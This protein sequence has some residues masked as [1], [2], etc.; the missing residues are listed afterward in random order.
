MAAV[1]A[2]LLK[3]VEIAA[4]FHKLA[5][6]GTAAFLLLDA[7][8]DAPLSARA[9]RRPAARRHALLPL[10]RITQ[11]A[12]FRTALAGLAARLPPRTHAALAIVRPLHDNHA[13]SAV[14]VHFHFF[15]II[16]VFAAGPV[17][18]AHLDAA[19]SLRPFAHI[20]A[21][22]LASAAA[23]ACVHG[24]LVAHAK[25]GNAM[26]GHAKAG[27]ETVDDAPVFR[28]HYA[29]IGAALFPYHNA[30]HLLRAAPWS[31]GPVIA[32]DLDA[33]GS[34][35]AIL[36]APCLV[37]R[38]L[39]ARRAVPRMAVRPGLRRRLKKRRQ[40]DSRGQYH[41]VDGSSHICLADCDE[42]IL[43]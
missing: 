1:H 21:T 29:G 14:L 19:P 24:T 27:S 42:S 31:A 22:L 37:L 9:L 17:I 30:L 3:L 6:R 28:E 36:L 33:H 7:H 40:H 35:P 2:A 4:K 23:H 26:T 5:R 16:F 20:A 13:A 32:C 39:L 12:A 8:H 11:A 43:R 10:A 15:A 41:Y 18:A 38:S 25:I 34:G